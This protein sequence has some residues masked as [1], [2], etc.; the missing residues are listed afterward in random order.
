MLG[1]DIIKNTADQRSTSTKCP[2][3]NWDTA[4]SKPNLMK[5]GIRGCAD[6]KFNRTKS[7]LT[8]HCAYEDN[9]LIKYFC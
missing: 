4:L 8:K 5:Y 2:A 1:C 3:E 6:Q 7:M 9:L